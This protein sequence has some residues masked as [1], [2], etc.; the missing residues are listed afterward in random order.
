MLYFFLSLIVTQEQGAWLPFIRL[1][2]LLIILLKMKTGTLLVTFN[3]LFVFFIHAFP[4]S[5]VIKSTHVDVI[6]DILYF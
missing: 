6:I 2:L 1:E 5:S 3:L 4:H